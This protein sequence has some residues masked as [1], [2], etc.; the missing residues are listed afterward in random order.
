MQQ[1]TNQE[2]FERLRLLVILH[3]TQE[4]VDALHE[5]K[6]RF[7]RVLDGS[8]GMRTTPPEGTNG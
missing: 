1:S 5:F 3:G 7:N 2:L 8:S 4:D 6:D